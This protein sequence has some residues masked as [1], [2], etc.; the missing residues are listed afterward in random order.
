MNKEYYEDPNTPGQFFQRLMYNT[1]FDVLEGNKKRRSDLT[2]RVSGNI[3]TSP[4]VVASSVIDCTNATGWAGGLAEHWLCTAYSATQE[5]ELVGNEVLS[6][7][8]F[9][10]T[11]TH[12]R[13]GWL[14]SV[15]NVGFN[16]LVY[17]DG[18]NEDPT[19]KRRIAVEGAFVAR[20]WPLDS[21]GKAL[22]S[23]LARSGT[24]TSELSFRVYEPV[25]FAEIFGDPPA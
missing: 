22:P 12:R 16:E 8:R 24:S 23:V 25:D 7:W 3:G 21:I 17:A 19:G 5:S 1:A 15:Q 20:P 13:D 9:N 2:L 18:V 11:F 6:F 4:F 10:A 14:L